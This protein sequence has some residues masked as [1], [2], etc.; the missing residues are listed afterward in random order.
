[1]EV[2]A[3]LGEP[4]PG[5]IV[6]DRVLPPI[7]IK[8][9]KGIYSHQ[10]VEPFPLLVFQRIPLH[11]CLFSNHPYQVRG[12]IFFG[13]FRFDDQPFKKWG[14]V[15]RVGTVGEDGGDGDY[16][17]DRNDGDDEREEDGGDRVYDEDG[18]CGGL[19]G[20]ST[21][22]IVRGD[23]VGGSGGGEFSNEGVVG[24]LIVGGMLIEIGGVDGCN[25][26]GTENE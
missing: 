6:V 2:S 3:Y 21:D 23:N 18:D 16:E 1:M 4:V 10:N 8:R 19:D 20:P 24:G 14:V 17:D 22:G 12:V 9:G 26:R 7:V 15:I 13:A 5:T 11:I 25:K